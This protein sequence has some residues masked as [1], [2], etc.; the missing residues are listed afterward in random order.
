M[1]LAQKPT[2]FDNKTHAK[3]S[4]RRILNAFNGAR[5]QLLAKKLDHG[6]MAT[7]FQNINTGAIYFPQA[8]RK[9]SMQRNL[10]ISTFL[11]S[12]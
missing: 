8:I 1:F 5:R 6:S 3:S 9:T 12:T 7:P 10:S 4:R 2:I 11:Q